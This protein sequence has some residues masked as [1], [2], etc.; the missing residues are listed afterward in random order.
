MGP[1]PALWAR[2]SELRTYYDSVE[3][4][5]DRQDLE[6]IGD[7]QQLLLE[8]Y[9]EITPI[10]RTLN[11]RRVRFRSLASSHLVRSLI[12]TLG[13]TSVIFVADK[14]SFFPRVIP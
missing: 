6:L 7:L 11:G 2:I 5:G 14:L 10:N 4:A 9:N 12:W 13:A 3:I 1:E 8:T